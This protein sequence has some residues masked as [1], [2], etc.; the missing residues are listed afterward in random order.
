[1]NNSIMMKKSLLI[2]IC[3][4]TGLAANIRAASRWS[5]NPYDFQYD[6]TVYLQVAAPS[7]DH[8][9]VAAFCGEECRGVGSLMTVADGKKYFYMRIR[10]NVA[11]GEQIT[12][13]VYNTITGKEVQADESITFETQAVVGMPSN[14]LKLSIF[15]IP[16]GDVNGDGRITAQDASL[17]LQL[18][19]QKIAPTIA[20][21]VYEAA[22]VNDD[23]NVTAQDASLILQYVAKKISW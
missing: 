9:E 5:V 3:L 17:V 19:A 4:L 21:I 12:F 1:M 15:D 14:P 20:G 8:Y 2:M 13:R 7:Q 23:G 10:S 6:M 18:V 22:D 11:S 16:R